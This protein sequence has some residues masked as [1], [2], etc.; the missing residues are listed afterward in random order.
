MRFIWEREGMSPPEQLRRALRIWL[1]LKGAPS[2]PIELSGE[3]HTP[4]RPID[5][6]ISIAVLRD[7]TRTVKEA[8]A[9]AGYSSVGGLARHFRRSLRLT[10]S[11]WRRRSRTERP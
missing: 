10:P 11:E 9:V 6:R 4:E 2:D 8:A 5:Q 7:P 1:E 3:A